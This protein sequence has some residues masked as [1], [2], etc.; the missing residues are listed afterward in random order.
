M[1]PFF[2]LAFGAAFNANALNGGFSS[3]LCLLDHGLSD[4]KVND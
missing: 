4:K 2:R 3:Y 1:P